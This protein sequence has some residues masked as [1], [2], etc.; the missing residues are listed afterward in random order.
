[1]SDAH[2]DSVTSKNGAKQNMPVNEG[3]DV[4]KKSHY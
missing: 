4:I 1:V 2:K 3:W